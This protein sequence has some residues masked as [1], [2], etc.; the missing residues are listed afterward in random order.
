VFLQPDSI[1]ARSIGRLDLLR[2]VDDSLGVVDQDGDKLFHTYAFS[3]RIGDLASSGSGAVSGIQIVGDDSGEYMLRGG[4]G[5][6]ELR[7]LAIDDSGCAVRK[8]TIDCRDRSTIDTCNMGQIKIKRRRIK[9]SLSPVLGA[10]RSW[11]AAQDCAG[12]TFALTAV[13]S[14][15]CQP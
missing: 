13:L 9:S 12:I 15:C 1:R 8:A 2:A 11:L 5:V 14:C 6:L 7:K 3:C 10:L 4:V